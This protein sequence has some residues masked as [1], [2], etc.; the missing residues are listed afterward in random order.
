MK[1][2][3]ASGSVEGR[4]VIELQGEMDIHTAPEF[5]AAALRVLHQMCSGNSVLVI[6]LSALTF[7]DCSGVSALLSVRRAAAARGHQVLVVGATGSVQRLLR[8]TAMESL[9]SL[10][11]PA[12]V[13][14]RTE[15]PRSELPR[16]EEAN[17]P[18][19]G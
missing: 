14:P 2:A 6:D 11:L 7:M 18:L 3:Y 10:E 19:Q 8:L 5:T 4:D 9:F 17:A 12:I 15:I 1:F 13:L 16:S